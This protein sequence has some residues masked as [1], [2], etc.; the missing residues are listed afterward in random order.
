MVGGREAG[1]RGRESRQEAASLVPVRLTAAEARGM[2]EQRERAGGPGIY[3]A[4]AQT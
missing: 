2:V 4:T 1:G 3:L